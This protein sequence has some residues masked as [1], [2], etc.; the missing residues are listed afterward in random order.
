MLGW[1][2]IEVGHDAGFEDR[3]SL[4][5]SHVLEFLGGDDLRPCGL[6]DDLQ[7][8]VTAFEANVLDVGL[9]RFTDPQTVQAE[10]DGERGVVTY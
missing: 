1:C 9:A 4:R 10:Q 5:G 8:P 7:R 3:A 6:A 2:V